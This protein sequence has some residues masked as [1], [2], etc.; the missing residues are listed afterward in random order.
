MSVRST[1]SGRGKY[2]GLGPNFRGTAS[3][4]GEG[5]WSG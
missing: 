2:A 1:K 5:Y 3:A 4:F